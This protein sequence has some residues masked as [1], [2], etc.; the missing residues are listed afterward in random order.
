MKTFWIVIPACDC[1]FLYV[2]GGLG[3]VRFGVRCT[4]SSVREIARA[5][6]GGKIGKSVESE[7][8][9]R[10]RKCEWDRIAEQARMGR[11]R[12]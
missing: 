4:Y 5:M 9:M 10:R 3:T 1:Y 11:C 8:A 7:D 2:T 12:E 6:E